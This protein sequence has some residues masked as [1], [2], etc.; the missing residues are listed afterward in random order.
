L[1][2]E[3]MGSI[4]NI[5]RIECPFGVVINHDDA[6]ILP[7]VEVGGCIEAHAV[8]PLLALGAGGVA[9]DAL[10]VFSIPIIGTIYIQD[11]ATVCLDTLTLCVIPNLAG[12][13]TGI[14]SD[15]PFKCLSSILAQNGRN[16]KD[17][18]RK[19]IF[20]KIG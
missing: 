14:H 3:D 16:V 8:V 11:R 18:G 4:H 2:I 10:L 13:E 7:V 6:L 9:S 5:G 15:S 1:V 12:S 19:A 17:L 20:M